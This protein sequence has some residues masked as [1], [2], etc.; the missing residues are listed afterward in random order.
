[1]A[2]SGEAEPAVAEQKVVPVVPV[3]AGGPKHGLNA[4]QTVAVHT[5]SIV[6][7]AGFCGTSPHVAQSLVY[8]MEQ[9]D[10]RFVHMHKHSRWLI[11][12]VAGPQAHKGDINAVKVLDDIRRTFFG[13]DTAAVA[14]NAAVADYTEDD[15]DPMDALDDVAA[16]VHKSTRKKF[17]TR[18][19]PVELTMPKRPPC[20]G[21]EQDQT[22][23]IYVYLKPGNRSLYLRMDCLD[24]LVSYAADEHHFQGI[25]R[26]EPEPL[27]GTAV[28]DYRVEWD[29]NEQVWEGTVLVGATAGQSTRCCPEDLPKNHWDRLAS[30][31][32]V[33]GFF[34]K[35]TRFSRKEAARDF[36]ELWCGA[37]QK[38]QRDVFETFWASRHESDESPNKKLRESIGVVGATAVAEITVKTEPS[39]VATYKPAVL[40]LT[41]KDESS[42]VADIT[43]KTEPSA[44]ATYQPAVAENL[45]IELCSSDDE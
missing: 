34:S 29:F 7:K 9:N 12:A 21:L 13:T 19:G 30:M 28:A 32:L 4:W 42:A 27:S 41:V 16:V 6:I 5:G 15:A 3:C 38:G 2:G 17:P 1:M 23:T 39:A 35:S 8:T 37:T 11:C 22:Q 40:E 43:V 36:V 25:V 45:V 20:S 14:D 33:R 44:A 26:E 24:W 10:W 18:R 31:S